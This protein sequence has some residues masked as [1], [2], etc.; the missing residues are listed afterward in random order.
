GEL[1]GGRP[2]PG[3]RPLTGPGLTKR[4]WNP[5][6]P[7]GARHR[8]AVTDGTARHAGHPSLHPIFSGPHRAATPPAVAPAPDGAPAATPPET[9]SPARVATAPGAQAA[10]ADPQH[11][12]AASV[13][14]EVFAAGVLT[15]GVLALLARM[16]RDQRQHRRPWRRIR[17]PSDRETMQAEQRLRAAAVPEH[18]QALT[19]RPALRELA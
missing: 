4:G 6:L 16:R 2:R 12:P 13:L 9:H 7:P 1:T 18:L 17:L 15:G 11:G 14:V 19:L 5:I 3:E 10:R 8:P